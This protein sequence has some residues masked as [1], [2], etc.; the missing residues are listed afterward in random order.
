M[1]LQGELYRGVLG[2]RTQIL[3]GLI[4]LLITT[5]IPKPYNPIDPFNG[6]L[7]ITLLITTHEPPSRPRIL[8]PKTPV[9]LKGGY[10]TQ[11]RRQIS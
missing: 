5:L 6:T 4:T 9:S 10:Q 7:L 2:F 8:N 3:H 11:A 1:E